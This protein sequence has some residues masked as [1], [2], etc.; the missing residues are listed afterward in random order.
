ME[1][2]GESEDYFPEVAD[3]QWQGQLSKRTASTG[4]PS[5]VP[6][7]A[8]APSSVPTDA[9]VDESPSKR[10]K[11][12][13]G[14]YVA[15]GNE[16]ADNHDHNAMQNQD[17]NLSQLINQQMNQQGNQQIN[18]KQ[19][20]T[21]TQN[22][23]HSPQK[24]P[25][26]TDG[27][28][29]QADNQSQ[30]AQKEVQKQP[31]KKTL[32]RNETEALGVLMEGRV[33][34][35]LDAP[36][37]LELRLDFEKEESASSS[38]RSHTA[39]STSIHVGNSLEYASP[40]GNWGELEVGKEVPQGHSGAEW[41]QHIAGSENNDQQWRLKAVSIMKA[42]ANMDT[43]KSMA[44]IS[45]QHVLLRTSWTLHELLRTTSLLELVQ[46]CQ[47]TPGAYCHWSQKK[48]LLDRLAQDGAPSEQPLCD[49]AIV[50]AATEEGR[51]RCMLCGAGAEQT[52]ITDLELPN[53]KES[54]K[55]ESDKKDSDKNESDEKQ[56]DNNE[57]DNKAKSQWVETTATACSD[58]C[59]AVLTA[60]YGKCVRKVK[61]IISGIL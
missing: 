43:L 31:K 3:I 57:S 6:T 53:N 13:G 28:A 41:L 17:H 52:R 7:P 24:R 19:S 26:N 27:G 30:N 11:V 47:L 32:K 22:L 58:V 21:T 15:G 1:A 59:V 50:T 10:R 55:K 40:E 8:D 35:V 18:A 16:N 60:A 33:G 37:S 38:K 36:V 48:A 14:E 56:T 46:R 2:A 5:S 9:E 44:K 45:L 42:N 61:E 54:D 49:A 12:E 20:Q 39:M 23:Q 34:N 29:N 51:L 25:Q 4:V